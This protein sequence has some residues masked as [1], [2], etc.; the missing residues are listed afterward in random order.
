MKLRALR[1]LYSPIP[2]CQPL[3][4]KSCRP[5]KSA[6]DAL[7]FGTPGTGTPMHLAGELLQQMTGIKMV[8]VPYKGGA[9]AMNDAI[10]GQIPL[11]IAGLA[12]AL[13]FVQ[14]GSLKLIAFTDARRLVLA[15][16]LPTI[17][18]CRFAWISGD[19]MVWFLCTGR[20]PVTI[21]NKL[22]LEI[23]KGARISRP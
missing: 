1:S 11:L 7:S 13:P 4:C 20:M 6:P 17:S 15:L 9:P 16:D 2:R 12:P 18:D 8:H 3:R 10:A 23:V 5:G 21:V 22:N 19:Y 14:S